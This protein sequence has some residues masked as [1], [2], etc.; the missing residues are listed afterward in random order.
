MSNEPRV[1]SWNDE[2]MQSQI[3][4]SSLSSCSTSSLDGISVSINSST[5]TNPDT[6]K[7]DTAVVALQDTQI[8]PHPAHHLILQ[9]SVIISSPQR[10]QISIYKLFFSNVLACTSDYFN[11]KKNILN[12]VTSVRKKL[13]KKKL[14]NFFKV[15]TDG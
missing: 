8:N 9:P 4:L 7:I 2:L 15:E 13:M 5:F 12:F 14:I 1:K 3:V 11:L 6:N 10:Y